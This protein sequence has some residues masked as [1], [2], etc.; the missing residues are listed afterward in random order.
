[1]KNNITREDL[2]VVIDFLK[3]DD[4][5]LTQ[6]RNVRAFEQEWSEWLGCKH[7]VLVNSGSS[8][9]LLTMT[10]IRET[11]GVG[12]IIVPTLTWVSDIS[13]VLQCGFKPVFVDI[14]PYTLGMDVQQVLSKITSQTRAVFLTHVLGY[15]ALTQ[16]LLDE[17]RDRNIPLIEDVCESHGATFQG[18]KLGTFSLMSNF[19]FYYA[20][21]MSTIE[22]GMICTDDAC[23]Y[24]TLRMLRSHGMVRESSADELKRSYQENHPD[25]NPDFIFAFPAYNVRTTEINAVIGRNQLKRLDANNLL[26]QRN[27][28]LFLDNLDPEKYRTDFA[29]DGSCNYAFTLIL[30]HPDDQFR[31]AV[32]AAMRAAKVEFRRGTSG[33][34]NQLRQPYLRK[35]MGDETYKQYPNVDHVHFYGFYIGNYPSLESQTILDLCCLLNDLQINDSKEMAKH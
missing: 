5:I 35:I 23:F 1:M 19:S 9:N 10:A 15:N 34:G 13:S 6:T 25:L 12:E 17:L 3:Q 14:D 16:V 8:A 32:M 11:Y 33:G 28:Q 7:S 30:K 24:Q 2:D 21:H 4:P 18:K 20:H 22:G 31:D 29:I 27:L 26:R